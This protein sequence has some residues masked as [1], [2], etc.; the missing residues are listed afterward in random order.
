MPEAQDKNLNPQETLECQCSN[1]TPP[2]IENLI[3][4]MVSREVAMQFKAALEQA[5]KYAEEVYREAFELFKKEVVAHEVKKA[6]VEAREAADMEAARKIERKFNLDNLIE[7][8]KSLPRVMGDIR[9]QIADKRQLQRNVRQALA[10]AEL[11]IKEAEASLLADITAEV[12]PATGKPMY[13]NDKARQAEMMARKK[14]DPDYLA[15]VEN[16]NAVKQQFDTL[17]DEIFDLDTKLKEA[18]AEFQ[19]ACKVLGAIIAE[20][21]IFAQTAKLGFNEIAAQENNNSEKGAW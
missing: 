13:S 1:H 14:T 3:S 15:A 2:T 10:D 7:T 18:E 9:S 4:D 11:T 6:V 21:N 12:N 8:V 17:D 20:M 5:G 19:G 16:Y